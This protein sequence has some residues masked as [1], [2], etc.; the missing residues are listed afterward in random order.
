[1]RN[2]RTTL[3]RHDTPGGDYHFDW[4]LAV[5]D[6]PAAR[7]RTYRL[8]ADPTRVEGPGARLSL[9]Q[10]PDHRPFYLDYEGPIS[11]GR[12]RITRIDDG[13]YT[14]PDLAQLPLHVQVIWSSGL[15]QR[16]RIESEAMIC[17]ECKV[18]R[19]EGENADSARNSSTTKLPPD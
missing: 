4:F 18:A 9:E 14:C 12:G 5:D 2:L 15:R 7:V 8:S 17:E 13:S 1:M 6:P 19:R 3:A 10:L 11:G 16:W